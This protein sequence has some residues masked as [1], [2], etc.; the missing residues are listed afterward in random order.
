VLKIS[1]AGFSGF[2]WGIGIPGTIGGAINGNAGA[3]GGCISDNIKEVEVLSLEEEVQSIVFKKED[4]DF[5][6]RS[7]IFKKTQK[8]VITKASFVFRKSDKDTILEKMKDIVQKRAG[9]QP[10]G[11]SAGS[12]FKNYEGVI[13][14]KYFKKYP[15]L[16]K[17]SENGFIPAGY[18]IDKCNL[19][20]IKIGDA[21][22]DAQ[23]GNFIINLGSAKADNVLK[24]VNIVKREV[25]GKFNISLQEEIKYIG[26]FN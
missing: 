21:Q 18:L 3:F 22:I 13:D 14:K 26:E 15:E 11:F 20:G 16:E 5:G 10:K 1:K 24:L 12:V 23:N 8:Y 2:E 19:K 25:K 9:K 7:S 4:C 6:Y 17:F